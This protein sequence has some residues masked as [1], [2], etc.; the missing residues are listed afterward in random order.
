MN[1]YKTSFKE[2]QAYSFENNS[3]CEVSKMK[4]Y[5][6]KYGYKCII[7]G[8]LKTNLEPWTESGYDIAKKIAK[9]LPGVT[10]CGDGSIYIEA[11]SFSKCHPE[12]EFIDKKGQRIAE[13]KCKTKIFK[14]SRKVLSTILSIKKK[15]LSELEEAINGY[16]KLIDTESKHIKEVEI[17]KEN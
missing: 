14:K 16:Q 9:K 12:D 6:T 1:N 3:P 7:T 5:R 15:E 17:W 11:T 8:L 13:S 10:V 4:I 2:W